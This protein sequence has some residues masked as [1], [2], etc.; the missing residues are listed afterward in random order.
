MLKAELESL[1]SWI[2]MESGCFYQQDF[3]KM[4]RLTSNQE[5]HSN[6]HIPVISWIIL[7]MINIQ[8]ISINGFKMGSNGNMEAGNRW[9]YS[10]RLMGLIR[11]WWFRQQ[12]KSRRQL[13][14]ISNSIQHRCWRKDMLSLILMIRSNNSKAFRWKE[15][16][17]SELLRFFKNKFFLNILKEKLCKNVML[18]VLWQPKNI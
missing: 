5:N 4:L 9:L 2:L 7:S 1:C 6:Y 11:L 16:G 3:Q 8:M 14:S 17:N 15:E 12:N 13:L 18:T 10:L